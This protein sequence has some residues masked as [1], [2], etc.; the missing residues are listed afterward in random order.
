MT[1]RSFAISS[2]EKKGGCFL[3]LCSSFSLLVLILSRVDLLYQMGVC[4]VKT[5]LKAKKK[6]IDL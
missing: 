2:S 3:L 4:F 1:L 6:K 5:G